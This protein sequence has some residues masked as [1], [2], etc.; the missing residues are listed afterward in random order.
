MEP[1]QIEDKIY[2]SPA[3]QLNMYIAENNKA[4]NHYH[5]S[6]YVAPLFSVFLQGN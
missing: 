6:Q 4:D 5:T 2:L 3:N 1:A